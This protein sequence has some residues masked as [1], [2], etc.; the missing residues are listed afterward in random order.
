MLECTKDEPLAQ[1]ETVL[2]KFGEVVTICIVAMVSMS[3]VKKC[4]RLT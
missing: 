2:A 3:S 1:K 4:Q